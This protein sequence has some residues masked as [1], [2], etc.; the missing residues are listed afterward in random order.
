MRFSVLKC[1]GSFLFSVS[2]A[3]GFFYGSISLL[4]KEPT[5][6]TPYYFGP[7]AFPI[8]D[9]VDKTSPTLNI[10]MSSNYFNGTR[11]DKTWDVTLKT[12]I[13][14]WSDRVNLS[15]WLPAAEWYRHSDLYLESCNVAPPYSDSARKGH[16]TGDVYVTTDMQILRELGKYR[17][18]ILLRAG[19]KTA[20]GGGSKIARYYD[21]PG[22]FFDAAF[23]KTFTLSKAHAAD[24]RL[25]VASGFLCWQ[26]AK[27]Q[28]NDAVMFGAKLKLR[29]NKFQISEAFSGY[30]GWEHMATNP[31]HLAHDFPMSFKTKATFA[32]ND[33]WT[34][35]GLYEQGLEDYSH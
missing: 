2:I 14:L 18:D 29:L 21:C 20:S 30:S 34:V 13:P 4:G 11:G 8:P 22:Y 32:V 27:D 23:A 33:H 28:Q 25:S 12:V 15:V 31:S 19:L 5:Y 7:N 24:L 6:V 17:P 3:C 9:I 1:A 35:F 10:E 16:M 26:T